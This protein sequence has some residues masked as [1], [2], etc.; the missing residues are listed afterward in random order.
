MMRTNRTKQKLAEGKTCFGVTMRFTSDQVVEIAAV[1]GCDFVIFDIE[2]EGFSLADLVSMT[3]T[4]DLAGITPIARVGRGFESFVDPLLSAGIQGFSLARVK[5][6]ADFEKLT[7]I[8][9]YYP[10]GKRTYYPVSRAGNYGLNVDDLDAWRANAN[11]QMLV[12]A[13]IEEKEALGNLDSLL[14]HPLLNVVECGRGDLRQSLGCPPIAEVAK[15]EEEVF[16]AAV[17]AGKYVFE[18]V[19]GERLNE[20]VWKEIRP[21]H[22]SMICGSASG[23]LSSAMFNMV[24]EVTAR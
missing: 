17:S 12:H 6:V 1:A 11:S 18:T 8:I 9:Y 3:R 14:A 19:S 4:A 21:G 15:L 23:I 10:Q 7:D 20:R 16:A 5:T 2:H 24:A 13:I 22:G